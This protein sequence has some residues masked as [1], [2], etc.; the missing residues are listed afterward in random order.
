[1]FETYGSRQDFF[2]SPHVLE[3]TIFCSRRLLPKH[4]FRFLKKLQKIKKLLNYIF[5]PKHN[6]KMDVSITLI[7]LGSHI[8]NWPM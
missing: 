7:L 3:L 1:M 6:F 2:L 4:F 5:Q 8:G